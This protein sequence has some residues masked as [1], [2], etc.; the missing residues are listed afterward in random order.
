MKNFKISYNY[1]T[2]AAATGSIEKLKLLQFITELQ[3]EGRI[4]KAYEDQIEAKENEK[5]Q[6]IGGS[7]ILRYTD[8]QNHNHTLYMAS[9]KSKRWNNNQ[10]KHLCSVTNPDIQVAIMQDENNHI[11][12]S[13]SIGKRRIP[14]NTSLDFE[15]EKYIDLS[16]DSEPLQAISYQKII[17]LETTPNSEKTKILIKEH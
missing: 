13:Q 17:E 9:Q 3:I 14:Y 6:Y 1:D 5:G 10:I 15:I 16:T 4:D 7:A 11:I 8:E 2:P 12:Y